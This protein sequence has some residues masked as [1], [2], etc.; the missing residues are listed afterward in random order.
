M[1]QQPDGLLVHQLRHHVGQHGANSVEALVG[2]A[3]IL[4]PHVIK[5]NLLDNE[6]GD[7]LAKFTARLHNTEAQ[8]DDLSR[9]EEVDNIAA[10]VLDQSADDAKGRQ[11]EILE[12]S[13]LRG[14]VEEGIQEEGNVRCVL[15]ASV[16]TQ[17]A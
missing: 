9:E 17:D 3:D 5:Q 7:G 2:L 13:A 10:V 16:A 14:G 15:L 12:R 1:L 11:A 4:Q 8:R 6:D